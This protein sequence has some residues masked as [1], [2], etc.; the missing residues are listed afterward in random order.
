M[1]QP[2]QLPAYLQNRQTRRLVEDA[3]AGLGT[4]LPAHISTEGTVFTLVDAAG[5][6][7]LVT[8]TGP[9]QK[10]YAQP[11]LDVCVVDINAA[12]GKRFYAE[13]Y[14]PD[15]SAAPTCWSA[16]GDVPSNDSVQKQ[17]RT[18]AECKLNERGSATS[19]FSGASIKACRDEKWLAL[20]VPHT[21]M[22]TIFRFTI[23]PGSFK[24]WRAYVEQFK[25]GP[26]DISD[27]VTRF[28]WVGQSQPNT[29]KFSAQSYI[30]ERT[31]QLAERA[32]VAKATDMIVGRDQAVV[33]IAGPAPQA[34]LPQHVVEE[35]QTAA[36]LPLNVSAPFAASPSPVQ[37]N[38]ASVA[39]APQ[40]SAE[41]PAPGRRRRNTAAPAAPAQQ[42]AP[43]QA[44]F[45]T[46]A[47]P[48]NGAAP[49]PTFGIQPGVAPDPALTATLANFFPQGNKQ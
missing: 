1:N 34:A 26:T 22:D 15:A 31:A 33:R 25:G 19:E 36:P 45:P 28:E 23:T 48:A 49:G 39:A 30:D 27:V 13:K 11:F 10:Q 9:D 20:F 29:L 14:S 8:F 43:L 35:P 44:P 4:S 40:N 41:A 21:G 3:T 5:A 37:Q 42:Q 47:A 18:C 16:N 24:N 7:Q 32:V 17:A 38:A 46:S 6:K 2:H 12:T